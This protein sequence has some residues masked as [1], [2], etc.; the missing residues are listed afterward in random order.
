[1]T[2]TTGHSYQTPPTQISKEAKFIGVNEVKTLMV[3][4]TWDEKAQET[5]EKGKAQAKAIG[6]DF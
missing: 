1:L 5:I 6:F 3:E 4:H 2:A